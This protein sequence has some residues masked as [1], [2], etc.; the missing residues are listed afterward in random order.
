MQKNS[1]KN[2]FNRLSLWLDMLFVDHGI[3]RILYN[4]VFQLSEKMYRS[5]QPA[6]FQVRRFNKDF[7]VKTIINLRGENKFGS[8]ILEKESCSET[9]VNLVDFR[10]YSRAMPTK[11][12][13]L[14]SLKLFNDIEY[15]AIM[16]CKSGADRAGLMSVLYLILKEGK[17][18]EIAIKQLS[19]KYGHFKQ[20]KTGILDHFFDLYIQYAKTNNIEFI[21]WVENVFDHEKAVQSFYS[22]W[23]AN[24]LV[25]KI[26]KRE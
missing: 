20:A 26:L 21:D 25:D 3:I 16:H 9:G 18:V 24:N 13:I 5:S 6:P 12:F 23:W 17:P 10:T 19:P 8:Y 2:L 22:S 7:G 4:N 1:T 14:D 15:P 11:K